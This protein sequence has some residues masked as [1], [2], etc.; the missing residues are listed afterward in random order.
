MWK[1][2]NLSRWST[3]N[4]E[5]SLILIITILIFMHSQVC[6]FWYPEWY[7]T[8]FTS[9]HEMNIS[10]TMNEVERNFVVAILHQPLIYGPA[11]GAWMETAWQD[12]ELSGRPSGNSAQRPKRKNKMPRF[13]F[14]QLGTRLIFFPLWPKDKTKELYRDSVELQ[15]SSKVI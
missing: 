7:L 3:W 13:G 1:S 2:K 14:L 11:G 12:A 6:E 10:L 15:Q 4:L 8:P 5:W 9:R